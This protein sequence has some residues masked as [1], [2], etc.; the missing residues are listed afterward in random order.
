MKHSY[1]GQRTGV[2]SSKASCTIFRHFRP[3]QI[4]PMMWIRRTQTAAKAMLK[5]GQSL[6]MCP[7]LGQAMQLFHP[8]IYPHKCL[9]IFLLPQK[10]LEDKTWFEMG[11]KN[12]NGEA[13]ASQVSLQTLLIAKSPICCLYSRSLNHGLG[14]L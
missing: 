1:L 12:L 8:P 7:T 14:V 9:P 6:L 5:T 13:I 11:V 2:E 10:Y 3:V 4:K